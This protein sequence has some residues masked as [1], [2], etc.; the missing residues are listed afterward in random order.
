MKF[1]EYLENTISD[2]EK[3]EA[4]LRQKIKD[5]N[6]AGEVRSLGEELSR[7]QSQKSAAVE[8]LGS[9]E[10]PKEDRSFDVLGT[11]GATKTEKRM[12]SKN[13]DI[14][15]SLEYR[16]AFMDYV[17]HGTPIPSEFRTTSVTGSPAV[18]PTTIMNEI[19][20]TYGVYGELYN[21][22]R[23]INVKGGVEYPVVSVIPAANWI[24]ADKASEESVNQSITA[25]ESV[26]FKYYGLECKI[27]QTL[28]S[29]VTSID[30]F[31][32]LFPQLAAEAIIKA[33][34]IGII[35]GTGSK[36]MT[37]VATD[38]R[39]A[40][41]GTVVTMTAADF[42]S[43]KGWKKQV[44]AKMKKAYRNGVFVMAQSTFDGYIDGMTD[45]V[46]QP[47]GR[48]NYGITNETARD[49]ET[50][51]FGGKRVITVEEDV[52]EGYDT[53]S[54]NDVVAVFFDPSNYV[55]NS[56]LQLTVVNWIDH[57]V[58]QRVTKA[59]MICD[60]KILDPSGVIVIKKAAAAASTESETKS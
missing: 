50:Y 17:C 34:D 9:I 23:H 16:Q 7:V 37:G 19:V 22:V 39:V 11:Y 57:D 38:P 20:R 32:A 33:L 1:K 42:S 12:D 13:T 40:S 30:A 4:E 44:F 18:V 8:Q 24:T 3:R 53:A 26:S 27:G 58:N 47:I 51:R 36:Q 59:I 48:V 14:Y 5:S 29:E 25:E 49:G 46:G 60:G 55:I 43:W 35:S 6:D 41:D 21:M 52:M 15:G 10:E 28:L 2:C 31:E 45:E 54:A 56:N